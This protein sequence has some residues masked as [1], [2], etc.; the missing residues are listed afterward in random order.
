MRRS[1]RQVRRSSRQVRPTRPALPPPPC[2]PSPPVCRP[3]P[4]RAPAAA[5]GR[6]AAGGRPGPAERGL[7]AGLRGMPTA[8]AQRGIGQ[9]IIAGPPCETGR[10]RRP[11]GTVGGRGPRGTP[12]RSAAAA[13]RR[14]AAAAG[15]PAL[16]GPAD[17]R[18]GEQGGARATRRVST[19]RGPW[20]PPPGPQRH[21]KAAPVPSPPAE[22]P[23][24]PSEAAGSIVASPPVG[25]AGG[26]QAGQAESPRPPPQAHALGPARFPGLEAARR[27]GGVLGLR[28]GAGQAWAGAGSR[29]RLFDP[30]G[31]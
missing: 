28:G 27:R 15:R 30:N 2:P 23:P 12:P 13:A 9:P 7:Q 16:C 25:S 24:P 3:D 18:A 22:P 5:L 11:G 20:P 4:L 8:Q 6:G 19:R 17:G 14:V 26:W 29:G 1:S 10:P 21:A 31:R